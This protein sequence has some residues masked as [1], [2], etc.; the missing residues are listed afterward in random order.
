MKRIILIILIIFNSVSIS[1]A[2]SIFLSRYQF[3]NFTYGETV[4]GLKMYSD[5][6]VIVT[7]RSL[8]GTIFGNA[9]SSFMMK[10][11]SSGNLLLSKLYY[12][13]SLNFSIN[14]T[15]FDDT[16]HLYSIGKGRD[17]TGPGSNNPFILKTDTSGNIIWFKSF[18]FSSTS[19]PSFAD[20]II[21][22]D[23]L[24]ITG[25][26]DYALGLS[27]MMLLGQLDTSGTV[28]HF[29]YFKSNHS[30]IG[31]RIRPYSSNEYIITGSI[32]VD[33][34]PSNDVSS[35]FYV[36]K[37]DSLFSPVWHS[38]FLTND[39]GT[40]KANAIFKVHDNRILIAG[41]ASQGGSSVYCFLME[42]DSLG[43][44]IQSKLYCF[45][46]NF[47][48]AQEILRVDSNHFVIYGYGI[49]NFL[50]IDSLGNP[51][52]S[53]R[54]W[55]GGGGTILDKGSLTNDNGMVLAYWKSPYGTISKADSLYNFNCEELNYP[56]CQTLP[57]VFD[58]FPFQPVDTSFTFTITDS[59]NSVA[60]NPQ[61]N[62]VCQ[63]A[64]GN[65]DLSINN[66][67]YALY[68]NPTNDVVNILFGSQTNG[69]R[70]IEL[71]DTKWILQLGC[72]T[73]EI[74][75]ILSVQHLIPGCYFVR[76]T[77]DYSSHVLK[78][79]KL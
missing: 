40:D 9:F 11:D 37:V 64:T 13:D 30:I 29:R 20:A 21:S 62:I 26:V 8:Y 61:Y 32:S 25:V 44:Q 22:D 17:I 72:I 35:C 18:N 55:G 65:P 73:N 78:F 54:I 52:G 12:M 48:E 38:A 3:H 1:Q 34:I 59:I 71:F 75:Y 42:L 28:D 39:N 33:T 50:R 2:Q 10:L 6:S 47:S 31:L 15:I 76:I 60:A 57:I 45:N 16:G 53:K 79:I 51:L 74:S 36:M 27:G 23:K 5:N 68:P 69:S 24:I 7:G 4:T 14:R 49:V 56:I 19:G 58:T 67:N 43:T 77:D 70:T 63:T 41:Q 66:Q 46:N